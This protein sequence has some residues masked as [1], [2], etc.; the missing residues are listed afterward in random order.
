MIGY[1]VLDFAG[2]TIE[3]DKFSVSTLIE[4]ANRNVGM[5][6]PHGLFVL[7][8]S[9]VTISILLNQV[10]D[11][12]ASAILQERTLMNLWCC[13]ETSQCQTDFKTLIP[14]QGEDASGLKP[15]MAMS[16]FPTAFL[17]SIVSLRHKVFLWDNFSS[18]SIFAKVSHFIEMVR[19]NK[20]QHVLV[21]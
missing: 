12:Y 7:S 14:A 5:Y 1:F 8:G 3:D 15:R 16:M 2:N 17:A 18:L 19:I 11:D 4:K 6:V 10:N 20:L 21:M 9:N 13:L